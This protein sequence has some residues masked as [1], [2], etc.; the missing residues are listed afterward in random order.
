MIGGF[1]FHSPK[2]SYF[3]PS[4]ILYKLLTRA[5]LLHFGISHRIVVSLCVT[6]SKTVD[7]LFF[8][9][10][11]SDSIKRSVCKVKLGLSQ[12][13]LGLHQEA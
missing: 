13:I 11:R 8:I 12:S 1:P 7:H 5:M 3:L 6:A 10:S 2:M 4:S 9:G